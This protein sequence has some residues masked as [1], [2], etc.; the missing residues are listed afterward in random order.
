MRVS[1]G[2]QAIIVLILITIVWGSAFTLVKQSLAQASP[3]AFIASRFW[4]AAAVTLICLPRSLLNISPATLR[5][6][7]VLS[8]FLLGGFIFQTLGLR[9]TTPSRS[10]FITSTSVLLVPVLGYVLFG[11]RPRLQTMAGV[12]LATVGLG[13]LTLERLELAFS[14]GDLLTFLCAIVF[15]LHILFLGRYLPASDFRQLFVLQMAGSALL[16]SL[17]LP[18][19]ERPFLVW[20]MI[21][22]SY[23]AVVGVLAT[24]VAFYAQTWAQ[25]FTTPNRTALIFSLE[26]FFAALFAYLML[27]H[28][29]TIR[30][31]IGGVLVMG[32]IVISEFRRAGEG[33]GS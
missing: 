33:L 18:V 15:A 5:R 25:R 10:A 16:C 11:R 14:Y 17:I 6:G 2:L 19:L 24:A 7:I 27:G 1:K 29:L 20:D 28:Q 12:A 3:I 4:I 22:I 32:G 31:W 13:L 23:L 30:E 21:L 26:P 9:W 8:I